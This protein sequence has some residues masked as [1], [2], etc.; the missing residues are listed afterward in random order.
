MNYLF[1]FGEFL[2]C[3]GPVFLVIAAVGA[4]LLWNSLPDEASKKKPKDKGGRSAS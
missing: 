4:G 2:F 1:E 3:I